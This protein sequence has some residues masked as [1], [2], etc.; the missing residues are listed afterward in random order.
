MVKDCF[1]KPRSARLTITSRRDARG[2]P[3]PT[4]SRGWSAA[5]PPYAL[6]L[7]AR[8]VGL[9]LLDAWW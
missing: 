6:L 5:H 1:A 3:S 4:S 7:A 9:A 8:G 2:Q